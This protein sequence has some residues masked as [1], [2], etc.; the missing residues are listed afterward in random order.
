MSKQ[1]KRHM[2]A[3]IKS[4]E[5]VDAITVADDGKVG[6]GTDSP[7]AKLAVL[8]GTDGITASFGG[9]IEARALTITSSTGGSSAGAMHT[10]GAPSIE[11][12]LAFST[13]TTERMRIDASG[14]LT[15]TP[16]GTTGAFKVQS[17]G[18]A[19]QVLLNNGVLTRFGNN[20]VPQVDNSYDL[21][22]GSNRWD[23]VFATNGTIQ[24]SD[25]R[26]KKDIADLDLGL[27]FV[28]KLRP[29]NYKFIDGKRTHQ[30]FIAQELEKVI[31]DSGKTTEQVAS[32][33]HSTSSEEG[34]EHDVYGIRY[35]E[36]IA[37]MVKAIQ[38]LKAELDEAKAEGAALRAELEALKVK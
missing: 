22:A 11:G 15:V 32:L 30:G 17:G 13:A 21:G 10:F 5:G 35:T 29:V 1:S 7:T 27:E 31:Q 12:I 2:G 24:T 6:I 28:Q 26:Q 16:A 38:E 19:N 37:P 4:T 3:S 33:I 25:A 14:N 36:L 34:L 18:F 20:V 9:A 8:R 23:D